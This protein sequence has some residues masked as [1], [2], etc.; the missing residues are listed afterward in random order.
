MLASHATL[1]SFFSTFNLIHHGFHKHTNRAISWGPLW[2]SPKWHHFEAL[3]TMAISSG[4]CKG[5]FSGVFI[6]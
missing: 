3:I 6:E 2:S 1:D 4:I 5:L